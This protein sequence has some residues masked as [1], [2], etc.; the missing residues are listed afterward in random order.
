L[1]QRPFT[2]HDLAREESKGVESQRKALGVRGVLFRCY[3]CPVCGG[4][5]VFIDVY[6]LDGETERDFQRRKEEL[7]QAAGEVQAGKVGVVI[8]ERPAHGPGGV[9]SGEGL[10]EWSNP[11]RKPS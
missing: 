4:E 2:G 5:G 3:H 10:R 9:H 8:E 7:R 6:P 11:S 1:C